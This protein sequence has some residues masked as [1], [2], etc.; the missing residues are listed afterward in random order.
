MPNTRDVRPVFKWLF[1]LS[2][3]FLVLLAVLSS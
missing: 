3:L 1:W 2:M